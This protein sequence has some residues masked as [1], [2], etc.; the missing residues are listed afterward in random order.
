MRPG[1][2]PGSRIRKPSVNSVDQSVRF[3][4]LVPQGGHSPPGDQSGVTLNTP[5]AGLRGFDLLGDFVDM[6]VQ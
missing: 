6:R 4:Q 3:I 1:D 2:P 5:R